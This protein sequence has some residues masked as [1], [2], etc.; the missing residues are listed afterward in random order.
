MASFCRCCSI[1]RP[2][3]VVRNPSVRIRRVRRLRLTCRVELTHQGVSLPALQERV[4]RLPDQIEAHCLGAVGREPSRIVAGCAPT[5]RIERRPPVRD[6]EQGERPVRGFH[7]VGGEAGGGE[8]DAHLDVRLLEMIPQGLDL[9]ATDRRLLSST[10]DQSSAPPDGERDDAFEFEQVS[11][12]RLGRGHTPVDAELG[13]LEPH[14][15]Q[16]AYDQDL[17]VFGCEPRQFQHPSSPSRAGPLRRRGADSTATF[18]VPPA[19]S[20]G[21]P[22]GVAP[23]PRSPHNEG[24]LC[25][26][27]AAIY[28]LHMNP[29][30][31]TKVLHR[32]PGASDWDVVELEWAMDRVAELIRKTRDETFIE[33]LPN[34][35]LVNMTPAMFALGG[36]TLDNEFNHVCQKFWR[37]LG[38]VAIENQ[39]RI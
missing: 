5:A 23:S 26:K 9:E 12:L 34:G 33:K 16:F 7:G 38:V 22:Q 1:R 35:K 39:A 29:N 37:G 11:L 36:A 19:P 27:G 13:D 24:T 32:K 18:R 6:A 4:G 2:L 17:E 21:P 8:Q 3:S 30:R 15:A 25:P 10:H 31:A 20:R 14:F 28:Q